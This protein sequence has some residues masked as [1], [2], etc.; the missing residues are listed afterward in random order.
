[1]GI[2]QFFNALVTGGLPL[3]VLAFAILSWTLHSGRLKGDSVKELQGSLESLRKSQK[4]K[5]TRQKIDPATNKWLRF[6][7]GFYGLVALYTWLLVE[8]DEV[9]GFV[10]GLGDIVLNFELQTLIS[11]VVRMFVESIMNFVVAISWPAYWLREA[12]EPWLLLLVAYAGYWLG[13][14]AA[15]RASHDAGFSAAIDEGLA[16]LRRLL[17]RFS[18][19]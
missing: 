9:I 3:F 17:A 16:R 14:Q 2:A 4:N 1:M 15:Q 10:G 5:K 7:G 13:I 19:D 18:G 8:W 11:L 12:N 6:G